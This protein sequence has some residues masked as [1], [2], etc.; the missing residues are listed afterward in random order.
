MNTASSSA[1]PA[2]SSIHPIASC[3]RTFC[4]VVAGALIAGCVTAP[5]PNA[6]ALMRLRAVA[7]ADLPQWN[8][9]AQRDAWPSFL[10]TCGALVARQASAVSWK[11]VCAA[12]ASVDARDALATRAF[13]EQHF[14][15]Y[16]VLAA[17]GSAVGLVTGYYE[18]LLR[19]S[20][21]RDERYR[22]ALYAP[23]D[24]LLTVDLA[25]LYPELK[26]K[27]VRG[28]IDG[29]RVVPYWPRADIESGKAAVSGKELLFVDD[30]ID[31]FFLQVQGSGRVQLPDS[32]IVRIGY[33]DQ[34][35]QPYRAIGRI[36]VERGELTVE[37]ASMQGIRQWGRDH[38][39][40]LP[41]LLA[42][43]PSYVFFRELPANPA[44]AID[45]PPGALG[46]PLAAGRAI[47]VDPR[48][49]PLGAPVY[50]A[51]TWPG[52]A[53]PLNRLMLAQDAGGAIRGPVRA[54]W[55]WGFGEDA[56]REAGRMREEG[57]LWLLWPKGVAP[58]QLPG[59]P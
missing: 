29:K 22:F 31:A 30:A 44:A 18:P 56:A 6:P 12:A 9:D 50:V 13:F 43:N 7:F 28:R 20:R 52:S 5:L 36:L 40:A 10:A 2:S 45:G 49:I 26:D 15:A 55:F 51:T 21:T 27:R 58:P 19:G 46:V 34:N 38:P 1:T 3:L 24:D 57:R 14:S 41:A 54:D 47:A 11:N 42:E 16:Q 25:E 17:D 32:G 59:A 39:D 33:A 53:R 4:V 37:Q 48:Y 8:D 35:G 23:P